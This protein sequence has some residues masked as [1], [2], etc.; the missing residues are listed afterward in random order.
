MKNKIT[1]TLIGIACIIF[2][3]KVYE[4]YLDMSSVSGKYVIDNISELEMINLAYFPNGNDTLIL[5]EN[6]KYYSKSFKSGIFNLHN[7]FPR[8]TINI[9]HREF[10]IKRNIFTRKVSIEIWEDRIFFVKAEEK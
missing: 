10:T 8:T 9:G 2:I 5:N 3:K 6:G 1:Y 7:G 4:N